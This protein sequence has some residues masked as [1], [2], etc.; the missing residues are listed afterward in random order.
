MNFQK[1]SNRLNYFFPKNRW[2]LL[3][4]EKD[5]Q[6][7]EDQLNSLIIAC[8]HWGSQLEFPLELDRNIFDNSK[9]VTDYLIAKL[10]GM[11]LLYSK[12]QFILA[13]EF[14]A[15]YDPFLANNL[16][17]R[18]LKLVDS[19]WG[20]LIHFGGNQSSHVL[21]IDESPSLHFLREAVEFFY[22]NLFHTHE[23]V[24]PET[25]NLDLTQSQIQI[26]KEFEERF[27]LSGKVSSVLNLLFTANTTEA[28]RQMKRDLKRDPMAIVVNCGE[29]S[30]YFLE[31]NTTV[32]LPPLPF[33]IYC[34]YLEQ[35]QGFR[36]KSRFELLQRAQYWYSRARMIGDIDSNGLIIERCFDPRDDKPFRDAINKI[37]QRFVAALGDELLAQPYIIS[38]P[39][40]GVKRISIHR[41]L[42]S[43]V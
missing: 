43:W 9:E 28:I 8:R 27:E 41:S 17:K 31:M 24:S 35:E 18:K 40:G 26:I 21:K 2:A 4:N 5:N 6:P 16:L 14:V 19:G 42:V 20:Y 38:G 3:V 7:T 25:E 11:S 23:L 33:A 34:L 22:R 39:N 30:I 32:I 29:R 15:G 10:P 37:K 12:K 1:A 36:N 13:R